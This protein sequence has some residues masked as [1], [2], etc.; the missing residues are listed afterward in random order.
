MHFY[1]NIVFLD[2]ISFLFDNIKIGSSKSNLCVV[3]KAMLS[4]KKT[5]LEKWLDIKVE[6]MILMSFKQVLDLRGLSRNDF[7]ATVHVR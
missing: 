7:F 2:N 3:K 5:F 1:Q 4:K 6:A